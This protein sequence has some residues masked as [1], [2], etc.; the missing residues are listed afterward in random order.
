M[1]LHITIITGLIVAVIACQDALDIGIPQPLA[2]GEFTGRAG[3]TVI[4][5]IQNS[6]ELPF[7][8][9]I[10]NIQESRCPSIVNCIRFG[11]VIV[12]TQ[13]RFLDQNQLTDYDFCLGDCPQKGTEFVSA[14]TLELFHQD[15]AFRIILKEVVPFPEVPGPAPTQTAVFNIMQL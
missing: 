8:F 1:K 12:F 14:D 9:E 5:E 13:L 11:E 7:V 6:S 2:D 10:V 4:S 15:A 3:E